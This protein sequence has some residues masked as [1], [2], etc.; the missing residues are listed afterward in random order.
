M[1]RR[2]RYKEPLGYPYSLEIFHVHYGAVWSY[3]CSF[4]NNWSSAL[5]FGKISS[6]LVVRCAMICHDV[7]KTN[8]AEYV[9]CL[10][11]RKWYLVPPPVCDICWFR[12]HLETTVNPNVVAVLNQLRE[13]WGITSW[14]GGS[15]TKPY[16]SM[17]TV[18]EGTA[19]PSKSYPK[20]LLSE[21]TCFHRENI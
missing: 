9:W 21:G 2:E 11:P 14:Q 20:Y 12:T 4:P 10:D 13:L 1:V 3:E 18:W 6:F 17:A 7:P 15:I 8:S 19:D 16:G 5:G